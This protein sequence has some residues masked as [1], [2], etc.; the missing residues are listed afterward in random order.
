[1]EPQHATGGISNLSSATVHGQHNQVGINHGGIVHNN[2]YAAAPLG[3]DRVPEQLPPGTVRFINRDRDI[4]ALDAWLRDLQAESDPGLAVVSGL[5]G[6]GK[7]E[8]VCHWARRTRDRFPGGRLFVDFAQLRKYTVGGDLNEALRWFLI[9]FGVSEDYMPAPFAERLALYRDH[10]ARRCLL[11]VLDDVPD[12]EVVAALAPTGPGSVLIATSTA[13][14]GEYG[15][16]YRLQRLDPF[17]QEAGTHMLAALAGEE[18]IAADPAAAAR[19]VD[20]CGGL[21]VALRVAAARL[22]RSAW[23]TVPALVDELADESVRLAALSRSPG[24]QGTEE[25]KENSVS[26]ALNLAYHHLPNNQARLYRVLGL[27]PFPAFDADTAAAA[28]QLP[29][30]AARELL[31]DLVESGLLQV[32]PTGY[33]RLHSLVHLHARDC[34]GADEPQQER[35][36]IS[37]R[38]LAHY[39]QRTALAD[40]ALRADRLRIVNLDE[41]IAQAHDPF[42]RDEEDSPKGRALA[43]LERE[44]PA[45]LA[46]LRE[47]ERQE[48]DRSVWELAEVLSVLYLHHRHV[49]EWE[50]TLRMGAAAAARQGRP[51]AEAR[52]RSMLSRPLLDQ[53]RDVEA[54]EQLERALTCA[55][56]SGHTALRASVQEFWGRYWERHDLALAEQ[57]IRCCLALNRQAGE[58]RGEALALYFLGTLQNSAGDPE[59]ALVTL[60]QALARFAACQ[61]PDVRMAPRVLTDRGRVHAGLGH[62]EPARHDL[63]SAVEALM[64]QDATHYEAQARVALADLLQS[65]GQPP[66]TWR[67]HLE[68]ARQIY[69]EG[70][71]PEAVVLKARLEELST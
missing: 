9:G 43:W 31:D 36:A 63:E 13:V 33:Y 68:R 54:K 71:S 57:A 61:P 53:N 12:P 70:G 56:V 46:V 7:T 24:R 41:V 17:G 22:R 62:A 32:D 60:D 58:S 47:A 8:T 6:V 2:Y 21:P 42:Q 16:D 51:D 5:P 35:H 3:V 44:R 50:E 30:T 23:L 19:L 66:E 67:P 29:Q 40:R 55:K 10:A 65:E 34:A 4:D 45:L 26:A 37:A 14:L 1:M 69:H 20:L 11:V 27:A 52:L 39:L 59:A 25:T 48:Q 18:R 49:G 28:A 64:A 38:F 15:G